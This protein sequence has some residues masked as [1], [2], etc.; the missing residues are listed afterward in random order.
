MSQVPFSVRLI[1]SVQYSKMNG[2]AEPLQKSE[3]KI[4][5]EHHEFYNDNHQ[6]GRSR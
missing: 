1:A 6:Q 4:W 2:F 3:T 5:E